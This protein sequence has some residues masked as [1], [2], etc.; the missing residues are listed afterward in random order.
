MK[1]RVNRSPKKKPKVRVPPIDTAIQI[2]CDSIDDLNNAQV[3]AM[4]IAMELNR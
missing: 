1:K 4:Y 2:I 3:R